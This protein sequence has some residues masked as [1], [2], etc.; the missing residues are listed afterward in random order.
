MDFRAV[1]VGTLK[2][3]N[4]YIGIGTGFVFFLL[5]VIV[6]WWQKTATK[7]PKPMSEERTPEQ[8]L[9]AEIELD[10]K[11]LELEESLDER[12]SKSGAALLDPDV[13]REGDDEAVQELLSIQAEIDAVRQA[14][15]IAREERAEAVRAQWSEKATTLRSKVQALKENAEQHGKKTDTLLEELR[16][17]E[18][19][20]YV[21]EQRH[22]GVPGR[23][24]AKPKSEMMLEEVE[25]LAKEAHERESRS[26][27]SGS[28]FG[29]NASSLVK[30]LLSM[31]TAVGPPPHEVRRW[32]EEAHQAAVD[33]AIALSGD[34]T[35]TRMAVERGQVRVRYT[36]VWRNGEID[37]RQSGCRLSMKTQGDRVAV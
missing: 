30:G 5:G 20:R 16:D 32:A 22:D 6:W 3:M 14:V 26:P 4:L 23:L 15:D 25:A 1:F 28:T 8:L 18:G 35:E 2:V 12:A 7:R 21:P 9:Q 27:W 36:L 11:L 37:E 29:Y 19:I 33:K 31:P 34:A 10:R 13:K 17:H 24:T